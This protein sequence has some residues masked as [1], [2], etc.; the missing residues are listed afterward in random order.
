MMSQ[1]FLSDR[2]IHT[3]NLSLTPMITLYEVLKLENKGIQFHSPP[4]TGIFT[5]GG[6]FLDLK[7]IE[8]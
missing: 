6:L 1:L 5:R 8:E 4:N 3:S 2:D 7:P